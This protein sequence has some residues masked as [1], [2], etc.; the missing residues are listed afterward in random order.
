[1]ARAESTAR[2]PGTYGQGTLS[3]IKTG[4]LAGRW[5]YTISLRGKRMEFYGKNAA[6]A[7]GKM[8][9]E[10]DKVKVGQK[11]MRRGLT[12]ARYADEWL[13]LPSTQ[14]KVRPSTYAIYVDNIERLIKP[15][16]GHF[17]LDV[18]EPD[19]IDRWHGLLAAKGLSTYS[20][21]NAHGVLRLIFKG[22]CH[23]KLLL[24]NPAALVSAPKPVHRQAKVL[25]PERTR[26]VVAALQG[27]PFEAAF[28]LLI[29]TGM[30][31]GEMRGLR[32]Q[33]VD[34]EHGQL[35]IQ[36]QI[37]RVRHQGV[38]VS[39]PKSKNGIR[40]VP[41]GKALRAVLLAHK[42]R[43]AFRQAGA[44][45]AWEDH[46][47]VVT[48]GRG[49]AVEATQLYNAWRQLLESH[50]WE[51][52]RIHDLRHSWVTHQM[53]AGADAAWVSKAAGHATVGFT[54][55]V[56]THMAAAPMQLADNMDRLLEEP[57]V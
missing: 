39:A 18:I 55:D 27:H 5:R 13:A 33:D 6:E 10:R 46:G 15:H 48:S 22:A 49:K 32:W 44:G 38:V 37:T 29:M 16:L 51:Y 40:P 50:G 12:I 23:N 2:K 7:R 4:R 30:R 24:V 36:R 25:N 8:E 41:M 31:K 14:T 54:I 3:E 9:A 53:E 47:L 26:E 17:K 45:D 20:I 42:D 21:R 43:Q 34:F 28:K 19:D 35:L 57:A 52:V 11:H 56:Y 1:M